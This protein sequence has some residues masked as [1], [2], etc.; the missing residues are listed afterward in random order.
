MTTLLSDLSVAA[1]AVRH[2]CTPRCIR[3]EINK[4][5]GPCV[6]GLTSDAVYAAA[7]E[8][9]RLFLAGRNDQLL[10]RLRAEMLA[11]SADL[12]RP[13]RRL[14]PLGVVKG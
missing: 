1:L 10:R 8:Q 7:V 5:L 9:A 3:H 2:G 14:V 11:A 12:V 13:V 4:C 6:A